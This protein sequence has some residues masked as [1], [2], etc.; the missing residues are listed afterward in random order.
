[1]SWQTERCQRLH[2][3]INEPCK[4]L[5]NFILDFG[6]LTPREVKVVGVESGGVPAL[7]A[8]AADKVRTLRVLITIGPRSL[9]GASAP[10]FFTVTEPV[11]H[12]QRRV[13]GSL[14]RGII[15]M[16]RLTGRGVLIW[17]VLFFGTVI[18]MNSYLHH[19]FIAYV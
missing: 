16:D 12:E 4:Q 15:M 6:G 19:G 14:S 2:D 5:R 18:A 8:V 9:S 1:M 13:A 3:Q 7:I 10:V 11:H 17:L